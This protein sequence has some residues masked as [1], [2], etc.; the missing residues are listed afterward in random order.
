MNMPNSIDEDQEMLEAIRAAFGD[1]AAKILEAD[2]PTDAMDLDELSLGD[3]ALDDLV[4]QIDETAPTADDSAAPKLTHNEDV[5]EKHVL[6]EL[7]GATFGIHMEN[8]HEIQEV[9]PVTLLPHVP[10]WVLGVTNVRGNIVSVVD[11][12]QLFGM[13]PTDSRSTSRRVVLVHS[14]VDTVETGLVLDHVIGI[15]NIPQK[16]IVTTDLAT[17]QVSQFMR[18]MID[19]EERLVALLDIDKLLSSEN[20]RQFDGV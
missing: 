9:P 12:R 10:E 16:K 7:A 8:I 3:V 18:G 4:K 15:R 13:E 5:V 17:D 14:L 19:I 1:D 2:S 11:L 20:F 6:I